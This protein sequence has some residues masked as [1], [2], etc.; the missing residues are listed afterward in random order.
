MSRDRV[1]GTNRCSVCDQDMAATSS[2]CCSTA[3][4]LASGATGVEARRWNSLAHHYEA[5]LTDPDGY[6]VMVNTPFTPDTK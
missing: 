5:T 3:T 1:T 2:R 4:S 6:I